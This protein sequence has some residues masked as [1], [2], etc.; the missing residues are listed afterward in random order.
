MTTDPLTSLLRA[1]AQRTDAA[2]DLTSAM[3]TLV[4]AVSIYKAAWRHATSLGWARTDLV[5]A[6]LV[7]PQRLPRNLARATPEPPPS[8]DAEHDQN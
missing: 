5:R 8:Q 7:D 3:S 4:N 1:D 2:R 6:G